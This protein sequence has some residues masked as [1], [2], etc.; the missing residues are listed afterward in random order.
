MCQISPEFR[1]FTLPFKRTQNSE[2][3]EIITMG[4]WDPLNGFKEPFL[5]LKKSQQ[6]IFLGPVWKKKW[7]KGNYLDF[8]FGKSSWCERWVNLGRRSDTSSPF[9]HFLSN[10]KTKSPPTGERDAAP[11]HEGSMWTSTWAPP[12]LA[13]WAV[14]EI[15]MASI[16]LLLKEHRNCWLTTYRGKNPCANEFE[17]S[18]QIVPFFANR[19]QSYGV[20]NLL[21]N[22]RREGA[23]SKN[24]LCQ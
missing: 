5:D 7:P 19:W 11:T 14:K 12:R 10:L 1:F 3:L 20:E 16:M 13:S 24:V 15:V 23:D 21:R 4:W 6:K 22:E 9:P 17:S 18:P 8:L 2:F